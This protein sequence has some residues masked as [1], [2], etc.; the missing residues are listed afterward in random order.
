MLNLKDS[1]V[2]FSYAELLTREGGVGTI[3]KQIKRFSE[4]DTAP[5]LRRAGAFLCAR[6]SSCVYT[7]QVG[8]PKAQ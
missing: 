2:S 1:K 5:A 7:V 4:P 3:A 6:H 8:T